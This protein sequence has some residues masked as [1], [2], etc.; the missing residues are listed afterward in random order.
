[1]SLNT[2]PLPCR[3]PASTGI[4]LDGC[5]T[6]SH[7]KKD[8]VL[9]GSQG[10]SDILTMKAAR[11]IAAIFNFASFCEDMFESYSTVRCTRVLQLSPRHLSVEINVRLV[12]FQG[13]TTGH[14]HPEVCTGAQCFHGR[15]RHS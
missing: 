9:Y 5:R 7:N 6:Q 2:V 8:T 10:Q 13:K 1:V 3:R 11:K 4:S 15:R 14:V 12:Y